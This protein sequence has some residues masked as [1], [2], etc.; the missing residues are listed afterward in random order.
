MNE[1][2][3]AELGDD[4]ARTFYVVD[5]DFRTFAQRNVGSVFYTP[6]GTTTASGGTDAAAIQA[7]VNACVDYRGDKVMYTPGAYEIGTALSLDVPNLRLMGPKR[8][9]PKANVVN[10]TATVASAYSLTAAALNVEIAH[11]RIVPLTAA[12]FMDVTAAANRGHLHH[13][14]YDATGV[15]ASTSTEFCNAAACND[16]LVED[17]SFYVDA[18]QG[19]AFTLAS[20][21]RWVWQDCDFT[22]GLTTVAWAS[23]FTFTTSALGNVMRRCFFRG[24]GGATAAVFTNVVT[25]IANVNGQLMVTDCRIDGTAVGATA[26]ETTFGTTTDI[27]FAEN[28]NTGDATTEGGLLAVLA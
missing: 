24:A 28:Y 7:A 13:L 5:T 3:L 21:L 15:A 26:F 14:W 8:G 25:G 17:C 23:V 1:R 12:K 27:E 10:V 9:H 16:W 6:G 19:D 18:A 4:I 22:V 11:H 2:Y 20:P